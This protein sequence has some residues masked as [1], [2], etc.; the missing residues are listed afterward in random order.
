MAI[1]FFQAIIMN[2]EGLVVIGAGLP[3]TG[4]LS[5][6]AALEQLVGPCYHGATPMVERQDHIPLWMEAL[7]EGRIDQ[8]ALREALQ[9][10]KAGLDLPFS[11]WYAGALILWVFCFA[12]TKS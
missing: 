6:R 8:A 11:G 3:R 2:S 1:N 7:S 5:T 4:T 10:Y 12:G 9:G